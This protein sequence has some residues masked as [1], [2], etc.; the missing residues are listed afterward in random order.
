MILWHPGGS[1]FQFLWIE[2]HDNG[3]FAIPMEITG[4]FRLANIP[5]IIVGHFN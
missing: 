4:L 5:G 2:F 3:L 1:P